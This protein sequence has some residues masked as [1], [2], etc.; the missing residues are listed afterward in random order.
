MEHVALFQ[1]L[2]RNV[3]IS[4][5]SLGF[6]FLGFLKPHGLLSP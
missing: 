4:V 6:T 3:D 2:S 5:T 1:I